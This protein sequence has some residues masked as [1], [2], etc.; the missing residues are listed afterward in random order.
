MSFCQNELKLIYF[1]IIFM[2]TDILSIVMTVAF[3][4]VIIYAVVSILKN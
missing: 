3:F 2:I 4:G 1:Y